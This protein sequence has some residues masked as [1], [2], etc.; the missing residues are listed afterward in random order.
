VFWEWD[1]VSK[2]NAIAVNH[3]ATEKRRREKAVSLE[4]SGPETNL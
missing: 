2:K 4:G 3:P 1:R